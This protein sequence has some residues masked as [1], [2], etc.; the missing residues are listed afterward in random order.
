M[1]M[2]TF[3]DGITRQQVTPSESWFSAISAALKSHATPDQSGYHVNA[4]AVSRDG[5]I[6]FGANHEM[7]KNDTVTH[8]EEAV[9]SALT[10]Q[11]PDDLIHVLAFVGVGG[12]I[13]S[14]CGNCRD[15]LKRYADLENL[16]IINAPKNGGESI[17]VCGKEFY[18]E[19][20]TAVPHPGMILASNGLVAARKA[21]RDAYDVYSKNSLPAYGAAIV[22]DGCIFRGSYHGNVAYHPN[23]PISAAIG[24][25]RDSDDPARKNVLSI[26]VAA[27]EMP[28]VHYK[29]RQ[30]ALEFA[31]AMQAL[32]GR[33]GPLPVYIV[34]GDDIYKTDT[35]EWL[36][37]PFSPSHLGM[38]DRIVEGYRKLFE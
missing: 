2:W 6:V 22:C 34:A 3:I 35:E 17:V 28:V 29:D 13:A 37:Y 7:A 8:G 24:N 4:G 27:E 23:L 18:K 12:T 15:A 30:D 9:I 20:F 19:S 11:Y 14:P 1:M 32:N 38:Q 36:P 16:V 21:E 26:I 31:E 25:F 33:E 10:S 5:H